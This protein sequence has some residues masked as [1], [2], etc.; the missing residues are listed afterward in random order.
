MEE[1][2]QTGY[3]MMAMYI[4]FFLGMNHLYKRNKNMINE[5][6][7]VFFTLNDFLKIFNN[8]NN[9][10][11]NNLMIN[12]V[13]NMDDDVDLD[14]DSDSDLP[15]LEDEK[16][17]Q[18]RYEDKYLDQ[19]IQMNNEYL[20]TEEEA[21]LKVEKT[22]EFI[23]KANELRNNQ[24]QLC[25]ENIMNGKK[26]IKFI[27]SSEY[28]EIYNNDDAEEEIEEHE[29]VLRRNSELK[30]KEELLE[31][32]EKELE[33][34]KRKDVDELE[35]EKNAFDYIINERMEKM[36]TNF[37]M[38]KTPLGNVLMV[39]NNKRSTFEYY[40]DLT[41]PYRFLEVVSRKYVKTFDC[42]HLYTDMK[43]EL[44]NAERKLDEKDAEEKRKLEEAK[45]IEEENKAN[46]VIDVVAPK[47]NV[48]AKFK[49]Y[50][51]EAGSGRV[52]T[53]PPPKNSIPNMNVKI[54]VNMKDKN[55]KILLKE[56]AN[57]Y[58]YE[59]KLSNFNFL[60][61]IDRKIFNKK[62]ALTFAD[63]KKMQK[64]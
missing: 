51:K 44:K 18:E 2:K 62:L 26:D 11:Y 20:L 29:L 32:N 59:G 30:C 10:L 43:E 53:A 54:N 12:F 17:V 41:I 55:D 9:G 37:V 33:Q 49:S 42:Y 24:I 13:N 14:T 38:E 1:N 8:L 39:Y 50:N 64:N 22:K 4:F 48:Y 28:Y 27:K 52:N 19:V 16:I 7:S 31:K 56:N 58:S 61:K 6:L 47:K 40:S 57:R 63:F 15:Q 60:Q 3:F 5:Q 34:L 36:K 23:I 45:R 35:E 21:A 25:E 46:N